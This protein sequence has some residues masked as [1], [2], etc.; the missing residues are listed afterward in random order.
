MEADFVSP[1]DELRRALP[2]CRA[3]GLVLSSHLFV[4][5]A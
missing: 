2:V 3:T 5:D 1:E 4:G